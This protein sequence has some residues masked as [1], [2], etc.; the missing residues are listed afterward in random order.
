MM[1]IVPKSTEAAMVAASMVASV[2]SLSGDGHGG[3]LGGGRTGSAAVK[4]WRWA[5]SAGGSVWAA[6]RLLGWVPV[7]PQLEL[8]ESGLGQLSLGWPRSL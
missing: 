2:G 6:G 7:G 5:G 3:G 4:D 8:Q 1:A